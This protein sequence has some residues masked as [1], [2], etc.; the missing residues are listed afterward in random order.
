MASVYN[1]I[2]IRKTREEIIMDDMLVK[3]IMVPLNDYA[4]V[5]VEASLFESLVALEKAQEKFDQT[6]YRHRAILVLD[7]SN[8]VIGKISQRDVLRALEPKYEKIVEEKSKFSRYGF[9]KNYMK[10]IFEQFDLWSK[11][12][13]QLVKNAAGLSVSSF[14]YKFDEGESI[15][16]N[17]SLTKAMHL[18][19]VGHHQS[20][21]VKRNNE[22]IGILRL[23]DVFHE[24]YELMVQITKTRS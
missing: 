23:T 8:H 12:I 13:N 22:I 10:N 17:A 2:Q 16:E 14:M 19:I 24:V 7:K 11:P 1:K 5:S 9:S 18:L 4:T 21:P 3:D 6:R 20:L 15:N